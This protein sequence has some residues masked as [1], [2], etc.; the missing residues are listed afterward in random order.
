MT[1]SLLC[2]LLAIGCTV[3]GSW[4]IVATFGLR[5]WRAEVKQLERELAEM[6]GAD[7]R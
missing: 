1:L 5:H 4:A 3:F 7:T 6:I 2:I